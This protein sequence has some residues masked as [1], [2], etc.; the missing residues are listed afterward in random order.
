MFTNT[1]SI[2]ATLAL[3]AAILGGTGLYST[4]FADKPAKSSKDERASDKA[5]QAELGKALSEML[6]KDGP[7]G[8]AAHIALSDRERV[9]GA[10]KKADTDEYKKLVKEFHDA[11]KSKYGHEYDPNAHTDELVAAGN[12]DR[13]EYEKREYVSVSLPKDQYEPEAELRYAHQNDNY[14]L[15]LANDLSGEQ[16][17][18]RITRALGR[19]VQFNGQWEKNNE[20][21][22][23]TRVARLMLATLDYDAKH[24][25]SEGRNKK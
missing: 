14:R 13:F 16:L 1:R 22:A 4:T 24:T 19:V 23:Y 11:W 15:T 25:R 21:A 10:L 8:L 2:T 20:Q 18:D 17:A 6:N 7:G 5:V 9:G 12:I 3:T